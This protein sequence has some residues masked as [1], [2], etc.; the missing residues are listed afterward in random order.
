MPSFEPPHG[1]PAGRPLTLPGRGTTWVRDAGVGEPGAPALV[2]LHGWTV[3]AALNWVHVFGPLA[4]AGFRVVALDHRGHGKGITPS[5][6]RRFRL[7][8][9]A[10]DVIALADALG[11]ERVVPV[12]Y[13]MGGPVAALTWR[14]H[15]D[16]VAGLVL[17]ATGCHF[18]SGSGPRFAGLGLAVRGG[19]LGFAAALRG[20]PPVVRQRAS[21]AILE[22]RAARLPD[23]ALAEV[24]GNETA[25]MVEAFAELRAFEARP[26]IGDVDV[27]TAVVVTTEDTVVPPAHQYELAGEMQGASV[28]PVPGDH[29]TC[30]TDP[31][32]FVPV[33]VDACRWVAARA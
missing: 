27:P 32:T 23:W 7:D 26:W 4:D 5:R 9:C 20:A 14:R 19:A 33:L 6:G 30:V 22:R 15:P 21:A 1:V 16:R 13:S 2:L 12:G 18:T 29:A 8:D 17:C 24:A 25:A 10:D 28:W 3:T 31:A 11:V